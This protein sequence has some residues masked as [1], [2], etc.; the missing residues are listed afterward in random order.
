M[1]DSEEEEIEVNVF[2]HKGTKYFINPLTKEVY[3]S[4]TQELVGVYNKETDEIEEE[5]EEEDEEDEEEE[6]INVKV[7]T[8]KGKKY[9]IDPKTNDVYDFDRQILIGRYDK[10]FDRINTEQE[11]ILIKQKKEKREREFEMEREETDRQRKIEYEKWVVESA[12]LR[13][14]DEDYKQRQYDEDMPVKFEVM[15]NIKGEY[16]QTFLG[17][18]TARTNR[19]YTLLLKPYGMYDPQTRK[20]D[21]SIKPPVREGYEDSDE[22]DLDAMIDELD[23]EIAEL[24]TEAEMSDEDY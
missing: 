13:K 11:L 8:H 21:K 12:R 20:V 14:I 16:K 2:T 15:E 7:W 6:E 4:E 9:L 18:K 19:V 1:S 17:Y 23:A 10:F 5:P 24:D 22:E 3:D